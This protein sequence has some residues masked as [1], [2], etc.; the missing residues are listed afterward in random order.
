[1]KQI[2]T[3]NLVTGEEKIISADVHLVNRIKSEISECKS[4]IRRYPNIGTV[5]DGSRFAT[6]K[7]L[8]SLEKKINDI[9]DKE[10]LF[11]DFHKT[12]L[13][14]IEALNEIYKNTDNESVHCI[15][16]GQKNA[17]E[18]VAYLIE[19]I[20]NYEEDTTKN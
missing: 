10:T 16:L 4:A 2:K 5:L 15:L 7:M 8:E 11:T 1:M 6:Q 20:N 9:T 17:L 14:D 18:T 3:F 12:L 13:Y 19:R